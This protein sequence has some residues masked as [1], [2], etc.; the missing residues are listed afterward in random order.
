VNR[1]HGPTGLDIGAST[2]EEI[3]LSIMAEIIAT[4]EVT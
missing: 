1:L 2:P 3:A 4:K